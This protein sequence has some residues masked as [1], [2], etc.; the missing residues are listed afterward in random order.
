M[1]DPKSCFVQRLTLKTKLKFV[2]KVLAYLKLFLKKNLSE[3]IRAGEWSIKNN[4]WES[5]EIYYF[6]SCS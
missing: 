4:L 3:L 5:V 6:L 2:R 1:E